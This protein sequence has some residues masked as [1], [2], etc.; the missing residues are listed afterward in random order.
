MEF[1]LTFTILCVFIF[2]SKQMK[3]NLKVAAFLVVIIVTAI[4]LTSGITKEDS[5]S[6]GGKDLVEE[7]YLQ[8]VRQNDNLKSVEDDIDKFYKKRN[9][10]IEKYSIFISYNN[11]YY[12]DARVNA[13]TIN[14][15]ANKQKANDII[16]KSEA[17]YK[18]KM[19]DWQNAVSALNASEKE[20]NDQH[21]LLKIMITEPMIAKYQYSDMPDN[22]KIKEAYMDLLKVIEKI[23][24]LTK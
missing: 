22:N 18:N 24:I 1:P 13:A 16:N 20:L 4:T 15:A 10:A 9:E 17:A 12:N 7:L 14:D 3:K 5:R 6:G 2:K 23:K 11:R 21:T 8:T 19:A